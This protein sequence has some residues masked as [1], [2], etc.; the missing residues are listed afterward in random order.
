MTQSKLYFYWSSGENWQHIDF[1]LQFEIDF[2]QSKKSRFLP[3]AFSSLYLVQ[4]E[5]A[6]GCLSVW[7]SLISVPKT[8]QRILSPC[9]RLGSSSGA[10]HCSPQREEIIIFSHL[11]LR[12]SKF[13]PLLN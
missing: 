3:H 4:R 8:S 11:I 13:S 10:G 12:E 7:Y 1:L 5:N 6:E 9:T 2:C